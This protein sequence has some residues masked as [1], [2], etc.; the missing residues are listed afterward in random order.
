[1]RS[2]T[3]VCSTHSTCI[4]ISITREKSHRS[5][6]SPRRVFCRSI[7][8]HRISHLLRLRRKHLHFQSNTFTARITHWDVRN[9]I[10]AS[11]CSCCTRHQ[12]TY[13]YFYVKP[14]DEVISSS[15]FSNIYVQA[16]AQRPAFFAIHSW[17]HFFL[18]QTDNFWISCKKS[19]H[20]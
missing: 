3:D 6:S 20:T 7:T 16:K 17:R 5:K 9:E 4:T 1:M 2:R 18:S 19:V 12:T 13:V 8:L 10:T 11:S 14:N 15:A